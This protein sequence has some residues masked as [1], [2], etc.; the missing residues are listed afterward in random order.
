MK[1]LKRL[2]HRMRPTNGLACTDESEVGK[3][4]HDVSLG[5]VRLANCHALASRTFCRRTA[6]QLREMRNQLSLLAEGRLVFSSTETWRTVYEEVLQACAVRRYLSVALIKS[7]DYWRDAPGDASVQFNFELVSHGFYVHRIFIIDEFFWPRT[8]PT[9]STRL[10]Q[11][12]CEQRMRGIDVSLVRLADLADDS[13]L[14]CDFGIYGDDSVGRQETDYEGRT[15]QYEITFGRECV[16]AA[17][18]Q[19]NQLR[20]FAK[21]FDDFIAEKS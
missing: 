5:M 18:D 7:D 12:I 6:L 10:F 15:I 4:M 16:A 9:P 17:E 8:A 11:W 13:S 2:W 14:V 3:A 21:P 20:L 1:A 19:W